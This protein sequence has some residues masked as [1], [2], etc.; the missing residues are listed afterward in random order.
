MIIDN[1]HSSVSVNKT[2]QRL[3]SEQTLVSH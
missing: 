2:Q 1:F 3:N